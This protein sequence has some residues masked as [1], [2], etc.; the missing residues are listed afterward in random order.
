MLLLLLLMMVFVRILEQLASQDTETAAEEQFT[1]VLFLLF[2]RHN[3]AAAAAA[4]FAGGQVERTVLH[5]VLF[6]GEGEAGMLSHLTLFNLGFFS[7]YFS[8]KAAL[9]ALA[10]EADRFAL[11]PS[12]LGGETVERGAGSFSLKFP[13]V[14]LLA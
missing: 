6:V 14:F 11:L 10:A 12:L 13:I 5:S 7:V 2:C 9:L 8:V 1:S 3:A 4:T